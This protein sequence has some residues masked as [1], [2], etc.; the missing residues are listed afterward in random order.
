MTRCPPGPPAVP[1]TEEGLARL[2]VPAGSSYGEKKE[3]T[4]LETQE[5]SLVTS[6]VMMGFHV[7]QHRSLFQL[8]LLFECFVITG[9]E[10]IGK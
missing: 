5:L 7:E 2:A 10:V 6:R 8:G 9:R 1:Q 4:V 3:R